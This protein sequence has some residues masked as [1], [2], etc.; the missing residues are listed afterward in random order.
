MGNGGATALRQGLGMGG[1]R[2]TTPTPR[3]IGVGERLLA[4]CRPFLEDTLAVQ[5]KLC[6]HSPNILLF[7]PALLLH[8]PFP[9]FAIALGRV[10]TVRGITFELKVA[11]CGVL[12]LLDWA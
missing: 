4:L 6:S 12:P 3:A 9:H 1:G 11:I 2:R 8:L 7:F 10:E 5:A